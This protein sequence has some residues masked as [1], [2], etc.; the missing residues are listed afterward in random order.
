[1]KQDLED[2]RQQVD[3][4]RALFAEYTQELYGRPGR[5]GVDVGPS[6]YS[7]SFTIDRQGSDGVD[8]MVVFCFDLTIASVWAKHG[9]GFPVLIHDSSLFADVDPRQYAKALKL[10]AVNSER[11]GFQ[12]ICCLNVGSLPKDHF[13]E[14]SLEPYVRLRLHDEGLE[15]RLLGKQL[16]P[17]EKNAT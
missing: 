15:G 12:Y 5:L 7:F 10:A 6:G 17:R 13:G 11:Y 16:P 9:K 2:R 3:E 14:F 4:V 8:Q 1:M